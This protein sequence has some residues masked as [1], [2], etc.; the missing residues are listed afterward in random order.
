MGFLDGNASDVAR[1]QKKRIKESKSLYGEAEDLAVESRDASLDLLDST[2]QRQMGENLKGSLKARRDLATREERALD[3][4]R[5]VT[6]DNPLAIAR[7]KMGFADEDQIKN[8]YGQFA[9]QRS[10]MLDSRMANELSVESNYLQQL[11]QA[12]MGKANMLASI[13]EHVD[14]GWGKTLAGIGGNI[15]GFKMFG[16]GGG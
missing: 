11:S 5:A 15:M 14:E 6:G 7:A 3:R 9:G 2:F 12:R 10:Q 8:V 16:S 13:Q 1:R 4:V